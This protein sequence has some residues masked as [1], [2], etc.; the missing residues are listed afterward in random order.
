MPHGLIPPGCQ[1]VLLG[2]ALTIEGLGDFAPMEEATP[3]GSL[4]VLQLDF[5]EY[6]SGEALAGLE[7]ACR[8]AGVY[9]WPGADYTVHVDAARPTVYLAWQKGM[10]WLPV[11]GVILGGILLPPLMGSLLWWLIPAEVKDL[12][13]TLIS[14]GMMMLLMFVMMSVIKPLA[15]PQEPKRLQEARA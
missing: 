11:I 15:S 8:E 5:A 9:R 13:S 14:M 6:P 7:Q 12:I 3:E 1:A 2:S 4:I 10:A